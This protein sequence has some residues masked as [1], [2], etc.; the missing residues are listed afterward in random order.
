MRAGARNRGRFM[1]STIA[2]VNRGAA[3]FT[4]DRLQAAAPA[5]S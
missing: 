5:N 3:D 4:C 2:Q 1:G